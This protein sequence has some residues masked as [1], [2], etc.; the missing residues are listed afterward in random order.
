MAHI[1]PYRRIVG[2]LRG[3]VMH[4]EIWSLMLWSVYPKGAEILSSG[5]PFP[6]DSMVKIFSPAPHANKSTII[7]MD[8]CPA[9]IEG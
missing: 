3:Y 7:S 4:I 6:Q 9:G 2:V 8:I 5:A 1:D